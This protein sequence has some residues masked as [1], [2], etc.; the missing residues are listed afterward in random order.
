MTEKEARRRLDACQTAYQTGRYEEAVAA[1]QRAVEEAPYLY[2]A[3]FYLAAGLSAL[4][5]VEEARLYYESA[6][7]KVDRDASL[8]D[9]AD[10]RRRIKAKLA[11]LP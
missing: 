2:D 9:P 10:M 6:L 4:G 7:R 11:S 1:C 5:R 3:Y 8:A